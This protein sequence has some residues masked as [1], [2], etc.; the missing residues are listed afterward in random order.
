MSDPAF[1]SLAQHINDGDKLSL[2]L[3][4]ENISIDALSFIA[5]RPSLTV[6]TN[7]YHLFRALDERGFQATLSDFDFSLLEKNSFEMI[8]YRVSKEK[9]VVHHIINKAGA[10]LKTDGKLIITGHKNEGTKTYIDKAKKYLGGSV[11]LARGDKGLLTAQLENT[12]TNA[13]ALDDKNYCEEISVPS[14]GIEFISKPGVYGWNKVDKGSQF[15]VENLERFLERVNL[16]AENTEPLKVVD[17]G[18]G[19]GYLSVCANRLL[20]AEFIATDNNIAAVDICKKNFSQHEVA[21]EVL[22]DDCGDSIQSLADFVLCN[23]PFHQGFE[24]SGDLT[25]KFLTATHRMLTNRGIALFVVN[26]F[27]GVEKK[28]RGLF[29]GVEVF[30]NNGSFKLVTLRK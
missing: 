19:Y 4:D 10:Y 24:T 15:L 20:T 6:I 30:E 23:P 22:V 29:S 13:Q 26:S 5:A 25:S 8:Y 9:P 21:G 28:A 2:W 3:V 11:E 1:Q 14:D 16:G 7:R 27:I 12:A 18:C 17:L